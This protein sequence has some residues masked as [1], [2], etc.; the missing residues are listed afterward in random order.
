MVARNLSIPHRFV[1]LSNIDVDGVDTIPLT[2]GWPG[3]WAKTELWKHDFGR[4]LYLDL[5]TLIAGSLDEVAEYPAQFAAC[6][7]SY[8]FAGG[9]PAGG[10]GIVDKY[11]SSCMVWD[12]DMSHAYHSFGEWAMQRFRGDQ[13]YL[14]AIHPDGETLPPEWFQKLKHRQAGPDGEKVI[15]SM[16]WKND[17][18]ARK[19]EWVKQIWQ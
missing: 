5:D 11:Q 16:P 4:T 13:D 8:T 3:W 18:A 2:E 6:P 9:A 1:C 19:F 15:L 10:P 14:S 12:C 17:E 7:P